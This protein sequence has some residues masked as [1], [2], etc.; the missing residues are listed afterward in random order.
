M[1]RKDREITDLNEIRNILSEASVCRL[2][3]YDKEA[4]EV[5]M[6]PMNFAW[7]LCEGALTLY[8]H[9][10]REGRKLDLLESRP[11]VSFELDCRHELVSH[12]TP[13]EYGFRY[14]CV[15][16]TGEAALLTEPKEKARALSLL[17][18]QQTGKPITVTEPMTASVA[19]IC[20][21]V[22]HYTCKAKH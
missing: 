8:F 10:A 21:T 3:F 9:S 6:V 12:E 5:Y 20:V 4:D 1:R 13:C 14:A 19:V 22:K 17:M 2:G 7:E 11:R 15:M 18:E 16:G